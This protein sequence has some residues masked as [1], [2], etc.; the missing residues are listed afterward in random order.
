MNDPKSMNEI[1]MRRASLND[2]LMANLVNKQYVV[3]N[4]FNQRLIPYQYIL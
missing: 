3:S 4:D 1:I 2:S